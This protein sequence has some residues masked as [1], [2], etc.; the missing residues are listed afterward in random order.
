MKYLISI[1]FILTQHFVFSQ[2]DT[3]KHFSLNFVI[4]AM[5]L[6]VTVGKTDLYFK[7]V[8]YAQNIGEKSDSVIIND[9]LKARNSKTS[10]NFGV[11]IK[12]RSIVTQIGFSPTFTGNLSNNAFFVGAGYSKSYKRWNIK[13]FVNYFYQYNE[14]KS[15]EESA[16]NKA[17]F[18]IDKHKTEENEISAYFNK[19]YNILAPSF[20]VEYKILDYFTLYAQ[21]AY[22]FV[23]KTKVEHGIY[24]PSGETNDENGTGISHDYKAYGFADQ[25]LEFEV[26][27][28]RVTNYNQIPIN[29][30]SNITASLGVSLYLFRPGQISSARENE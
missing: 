1:I 30:K 20:E 10:L 6:P 4:G 26:N 19:E 27:K 29:L 3:I 5:R 17:Y 8:D 23:Y 25:H 22:L 13:A 14:Y 24:Y 16:K 2:Y 11:Q 9:Q 12:Y 21:V 18:V 7:F 28:T 15:D